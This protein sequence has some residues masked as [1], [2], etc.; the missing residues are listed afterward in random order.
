MGYGRGGGS[1]RPYN[2]AMFRLTREIRFAVNDTPGAVGEP[3]RAD[4]VSN[5]YAGWPSLRGVG[6]YFALQ[7]TLRGDLDPTSQYLVNI[8]RMDAVARERAVDAL[9]ACV[10]ERAGCNVARRVAD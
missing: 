7:M 2:A 6:H 9:R 4:P 8:K 10:A 1:R 3:E 5:S